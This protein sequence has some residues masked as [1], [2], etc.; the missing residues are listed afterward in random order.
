MHVKVLKAT[1]KRIQIECI[2]Y[3]LVSKKW[4][5]GGNINQSK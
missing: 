5:E 4:N 2:T 1:S 3:K